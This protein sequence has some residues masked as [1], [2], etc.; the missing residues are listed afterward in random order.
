[1]AYF[2]NG[3]E[4]D[5]YQERYCSRCS[6]GQSDDCAVWDAHLMY[7]GEGGARDVLDWLIPIVNGW[8]G[9]CRMFNATKAR[10]GRPLSVADIFAVSG[11]S[12]EQEADHG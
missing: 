1:M 4:G 5:M 11:R 9:K 7:N 3:T 2:S 12:E 10:R 8:P 6:H